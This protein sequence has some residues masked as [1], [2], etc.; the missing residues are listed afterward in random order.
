MRS[1]ESSAKFGTVVT[2]EVPSRYN[3]LWRH[4]QGW[5]LVSFDE[6]VC[7]EHGWICAC[8]WPGWVMG[9]Q[10]VVGGHTEFTW[11]ERR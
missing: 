9:C 5:G 2:W 4:H 3:H 8:R 11:Q 7:D 6:Q 1:G 10:G